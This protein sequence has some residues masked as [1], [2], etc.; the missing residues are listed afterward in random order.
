MLNL[1]NVFL[2][3]LIFCS[4]HAR[5]DR[6]RAQRNLFP[7]SIKNKMDAYCLLR[8]CCLDRT[9]AQ[10]SAITPPRQQGTSKISQTLRF[11][12]IGSLYDFVLQ[13]NS[14]GGCYSSAPCLNV[15]CSMGGWLAQ[16]GE[17]NGHQKFIK[18]LLNNYIIEAMIYIMSQ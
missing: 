16:S 7:Y 13:R 6:V 11:I 12:L 14:D 17:K 18:N 8:P 4:K 3:N 2:V 5:H 15:V 9:S 10:F 1:K